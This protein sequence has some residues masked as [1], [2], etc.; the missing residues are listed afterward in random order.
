MKLFLV[1][2]HRWVLTGPCW[3]Q[4]L[5]SSLI[6]TPGAFLKKQWMNV[7][8]P[9]CKSVSEKTLCWTLIALQHLCQNSSWDDVLVHS[10]SL[11]C[12]F[13]PFDLNISIFP[14]A[15]LCVACNS[16]QQCGLCT[17]IT[18]APGWVGFSGL[19]YRCWGSISA[20][21]SCSAWAF[22]RVP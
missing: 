12:S 7:P 15:F 20:F 4:L 16:C 1:S 21:W 14:C 6:D 2:T 19:W 10:P 11:D 8:L 17:I 5:V 13:N 9:F 3:Q 22:D 18:A